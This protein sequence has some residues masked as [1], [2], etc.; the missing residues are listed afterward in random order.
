MLSADRASATVPRHRKTR[1]RVFEPCRRRGAGAHS[2][3]VPDRLRKIALYQYS[4]ASDPPVSTVSGFANDG[5]MNPIYVPRGTVTM[6]LPRYVYQHCAMSMCHGNTALPFERGYLTDEESQSLAFEAGTLILGWP[7]GGGA[8]VIPKVAN[9]KL[10]NLVSDL[11]KGA[12]GP[13]P[14]GTGSTA[15]AI[16]HELATGLPTHGYYHSDKGRQYINALNN[17]LR[18]N[19]NADYYD[20]VV[21]E[22]L[23]MDL[24]AALQGL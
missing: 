20:R 6:G 5:V 12:R 11:Y 21:A 16:R 2:P 17:W 19:P 10:A 23:R 22:S 18:K 13:K 1:I 15:D 7:L 4:I 9:P 3:Q 24:E 8:R 14:I